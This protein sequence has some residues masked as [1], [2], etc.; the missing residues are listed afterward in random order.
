[1]MMMVMLVHAAVACLSLQAQ[2]KY[3]RAAAHF[4][5]AGTAYEAAASLKGTDRPGHSKVCADGRIRCWRSLGLIY[6]DLK[7]HERAEQT[8]NMALDVA[9]E[10]RARAC[11]GGGGGRGGGGQHLGGRRGR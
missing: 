2:G 10:V 5:Q 7:A 6:L 1:M 4:K 3:Q 9:R 11:G 8:L